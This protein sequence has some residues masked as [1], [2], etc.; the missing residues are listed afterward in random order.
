MQNRPEETER[1]NLLSD[2]RPEHLQYADYYKRV[3][4]P[5]PWIEFLKET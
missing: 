3:K 5:S 2:L 4:L 1:W